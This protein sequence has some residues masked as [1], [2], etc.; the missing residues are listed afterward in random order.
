MKNYRKVPIFDLV[1]HHF[2]YFLSLLTI[3]ICLKYAQRLVT[4]LEKAV[5]VMVKIFVELNEI[6][7]TEL[8]FANSSKIQYLPDH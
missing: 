2:V 1:V 7:D 5:P 4:H 8:L 6:F 3:D